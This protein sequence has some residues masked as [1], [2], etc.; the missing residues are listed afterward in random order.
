LTAF[1]YA[2]SE[3]RQVVVASD[4]Y[5]IPASGQAIWTKYCDQWKDRLTA[6]RTEEGQLFTA[7]CLL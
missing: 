4:E 1:G 3:L 6:F 5:A 2:G 7:V